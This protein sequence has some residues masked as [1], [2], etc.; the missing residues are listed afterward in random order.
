MRTRNTCNFIIVAALVLLLAGCSGSQKSKETELAQPPRLDRTVGDLAE[1]VAFNPIPVR[2]I[3]IVVGL[4][5]TGSAE[6]PPGARDY[7]RQYILAQLGQRKTVNPDMMINSIDTA[8]VYVEGLIPPGAVRQEAFDIRV[9]ALPGTQTTSLQS[10]RLYTTDLK[11]VGRFEEAI[12][13]SKTLALAA[14]VIYIDNIAQPSPD[15]RIGYVLGGG[16]VTQDHQITLALF[17]P[18]FTT[19]AA[20]RNRI[21][22]RFGRDTATA[23]SDS[24]IRLTLPRG[25]EGR[26]EKFIKLVRALY[27]GTSAVAENRQI[28]WLILKLQAEQAKE[29][30]E[31]GLESLGKPAVS[32]LLPLLKSDDLR[33]RFSAAR[34]LFSIGD[35]RAL[36]CLRDFAQDPTSAFR[37]AAIEAVGDTAGKQDVIAIM[38]RLVRDDDFKVRYTAYKYLAKFDG[39][40]IIRTAIAQDFYID[41]IIQLSPKTIYVSR[42]DKPRIVLFGAPID[43]EKNIFIESDDG[44]IIINALPDENRISVMRK[45]PVTDELMGPLKASYR[46]ADVIRILGDVTAPEDDKKRIGLGAPYCQIVELLKKMCE[47]GTVKA[48]FVAGPLSPIMQLRQPQQPSQPQKDNDG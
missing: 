40:S 45:H 15:P 20:L 27:I 39:A 3:G 42:K 11:L 25:F 13:A 14:G 18:D 34:C 26:K 37:I 23:T 19:A 36:K 6:C 22:E 35:G 2:G 8:V 41:Q 7:L 12:T 28:N 43:C 5:G 21:N 24:M 44:R 48:E 9:M 31:T 10:G 1:I 33:I 16:K 46:L 29:K 38:S 47:K 17:T 30:Y 32:R 4:A